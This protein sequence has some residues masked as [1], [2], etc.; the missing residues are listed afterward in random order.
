MWLE[1]HA[2]SP[3]RGETALM[4]LGGRYRSHQTRVGAA[5]VVAPEHELPCNVRRR[6][7]AIS[8]R[9]LEAGKQV[10]LRK[11]GLY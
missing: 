3:R 7:L 5:F 2:K 9:L 6:V 4:S 11:L 8:C 10:L 1:V